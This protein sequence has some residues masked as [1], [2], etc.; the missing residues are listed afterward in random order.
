M[1]RLALS[2]LLLAAGFMAGLVVTG[3]MRT[4]SE[5]RAEP[6]P[7]VEQAQTP[8]PRPVAAAAA[9]FGAPDFTRVA[10]QSV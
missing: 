3:R 5:G 10:G 2:T 8:A 6:A 7:V 4:A 1:R 9:P